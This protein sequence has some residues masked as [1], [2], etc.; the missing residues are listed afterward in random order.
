MHEKMNAGTHFQIRR[1]TQTL[2][3]GMFAVLLCL[4]LAQ[5]LYAQDSEKGAASG[6]KKIL[7]LQPGVNSTPSMNSLKWV[8]PAGNVFGYIY[9]DST[10]VLRTYSDSSTLEYTRDLKYYMQIRALKDPVDGVL[11]LNVV[12]DSIDYRFR[13]GDQEIAYSEQKKIELKFPD[14]VAATV[15]VNREYF[16]K[17]SPYYEAVGVTG[18][19]LD[20]LVNYIN[21]HGEGHIDAMQKFVWMNGISTSALAQYCDMQKGALPN[22]KVSKDSTWI[23]P[24]FIKVDGLDCRD[25]SAASKITGY[26]SATYTVETESKHLEVMPCQQRLYRIDAMV[27]VKGGSGTGKQVLQMNRR[28]II[29]DSRSSFETTVQAQ[30]RKEVFSQKVSSNYHWTFLGV[31]EY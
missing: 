12:I 2:L 11:E 24:Y 15:P 17:F 18:E 14:L 4:G 9:H 16:I 5:N 25:D 31:R 27:T 3:G 6:K 19:M 29:T 21:E 26:S 7:E 30:V 10:R 1:S 23:K 22:G 20:W 13:S 28:G 8:F